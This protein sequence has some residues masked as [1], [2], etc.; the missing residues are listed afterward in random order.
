VRAHVL[1][2]EKGPAAVGD[3]GADAASDEAKD[4]EDDAVVLQSGIAVLEPRLFVV[5]NEPRGLELDGC[6]CW[7]CQDVVSLLTLT[8]FR[9]RG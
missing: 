6:F 1:W 4:P 2:S 5:A 3:V 9:G 8:S 7:D